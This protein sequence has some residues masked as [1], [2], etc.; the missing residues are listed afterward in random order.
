MKNKLFLLFILFVSQ[1]YPQRVYTLDDDKSYTDSLTQLIKSTRVDSIKCISSFRLADLYR[2]GKKNELADEYLA[3]ANT[4]APKY[5][6]LKDVAVY[7][8]SI[9]YLGKGDI[10]NFGKQLSLANTKLKKYKTKDSYSL[11]AYILR[12]LSIVK[13]VQNNEKEAMRILIEEAMPLAEKGGNYEVL[14]GL[15][16]SVAI[17]FMNNEERTKAETYLKSAKEYIEKASK[18]SYTYKETKVEIYVIDSENMTHL[19]KLVDAKKSL[20]KAYEILKKYP[21]SNM[22]GGYYFSEG[23]YFYKIK[24]FENSLKSY[25]KGIA[26][27]MLYQDVFSANRLKFAKHLPFKAMN[28][29]EDVKN[30]LL[31]LIE[32]SNPFIVDEKNYSLELAQTFEKLGD[33]K[34]AYKYSSRYIALNDS[35]NE[36]QSKEKITALEAKFNKAE[37]EKKIS[38]LEAQRERD[39]LIAENNKLYYGLL[40]A[41]SVLLLLLVIF[42]WINSKNQKK[43]AIEH[44]KNYT[45]NLTALKNQKEIEV[46]QAMIKGEESE[47]K[48]I[49]RDLHDGIGSMLSSLK[50][51]FMKVNSSSEVDL[52]EIDN[53][54]TLLTNSI[55]ELRQVSYNLIPES[56]LKLGLEHALNDL[57]HMLKTENVRIDFHANAIKDDIPESMQITIYRI[58]QE[59]LSNALKHSKSSEIL[60]DCSQ[61]QSRFFITVED[62]GIGFDTSKM[63]VFEGQGL[64]NLK[65]RVELL[66]GKIEID[67]S[68]E[69]GTV[70]N[71]ELSL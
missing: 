63:D 52:N 33:I 37:N 68:K 47:R 57:C 51:R 69:R 12:N 18:S 14:S 25:D 49:A 70:F 61:N 71:I 28:R 35:L 9:P 58:V 42:L 56:L 34:N 62:N 27:S 15:Y 31:D 43:I 50:M 5:P 41:I 26:N 21:K 32:N 60:V 36:I 23:Y 46:M 16:K 29:H 6:F 45:Q 40:V 66:N 54:N 44:A 13:Q 39:K 2:R 7:Y 64:K 3:L 11:R 48:R 65:N 22:N 53:M 30:V 17:I 67:S 24:Q 1:A 38:Q 20:D 8:N 19:E 4:I 55:T 10:D 59:L